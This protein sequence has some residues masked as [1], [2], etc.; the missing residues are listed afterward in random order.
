L[1]LTAKSIALSGSLTP[2]AWDDVLTS[3]L[4]NLGLPVF[5]L[6]HLEKLP[7]TM[8][9]P[10]DMNFAS[11]T[12][13]RSPHH[14]YQIVTPI[15]L[16]AV[17]HLQPGQNLLRQRLHHLPAGYEF[18]VL[19]AIRELEPVCLRIANHCAAK[20]SSPE[21]IVAIF[22]D[23]YAMAFRGLSWPGHQRGRPRLSRPRLR[24]RML[25]C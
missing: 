16:P 25:S 24:P 9:D 10:S 18:S 17:N 5:F 13:P 11:N 21:E 6:P 7:L 19:R 1:H 20:Q 8:R 15:Q 23:F 22:Q 4:I 12:F 3:S 2:A 14:H